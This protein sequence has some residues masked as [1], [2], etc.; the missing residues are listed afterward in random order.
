MKSERDTA[1]IEHGTNAGYNAH[2]RHKTEACRECKD[3]HALYVRARRK[4]QSDSPIRR[5]GSRM[6]RLSL[7]LFVD[8]YWTASPK[9]LAMLDEQFGERKVDKLIKQAEENCDPAT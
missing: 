5:R 8:L 2:Y 6:V 9:A 4:R 3:A 7:E 1:P